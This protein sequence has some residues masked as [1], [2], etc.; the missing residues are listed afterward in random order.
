MFP[1][2]NLWN[3]QGGNRGQ[4]EYN[5]NQAYLYLDKEERLSYHE[6]TVAWIS[7]AFAI[8]YFIL[9]FL[10]YCDGNAIPE[11]PSQQAGLEDP[12]TSYRAESDCG[13][14]A[15]EG[16]LERAQTAA[17]TEF[18]SNA[19]G[20]LSFASAAAFAGLFAASLAT[21]AGGGGGRMAEEGKLVNVAAVLAWLAV[22][23]ASCSGRRA[24]VDLFLDR[25]R[26][27]PDDR[28]GTLGVGLLTGSSVYFGVMLFTVFALLV[29]VSGEAR[30]RDEVPGVV[31]ASSVVCFV[32]GSAYLAFGYQAVKYKG[33]LMRSALQDASNAAAR[34]R[35]GFARKDHSNEISRF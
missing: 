15:N 34:S 24:S 31:T 11:V 6:N 18:L 25:V 29:D 30:E 10:L 23:A 28:G 19:W 4:G 20:M 1:T 35:G 12:V 33:S 9:S 8:V 17:R 26:E 14:A 3:V 22:V 21:L 7:L 16:D 32:L 2:L 5:Y 13:S 27:D